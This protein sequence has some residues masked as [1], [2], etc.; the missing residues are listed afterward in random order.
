MKREML[1]KKTSICENKSANKAVENQ[2]LF[3]KKKFA[4]EGAEGR[5]VQWLLKGVFFRSAWD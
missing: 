5:F 3:I 4:A 1:Q 2:C